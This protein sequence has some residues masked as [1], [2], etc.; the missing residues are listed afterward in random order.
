MLRKAVVWPPQVKEVVA[1]R[2]AAAEGN[3]NLNVSS[4]YLPQYQSVR[5][6]SKHE[7]HKHLTFSK[8]GKNFTRRPLIDQKLL[9][10]GAPVSATLDLGDMTKV[11]KFEFDVAA[12]NTRG[13]LRYQKAYAP[14]TNA[15]ETVLQLCESVFSK[16]SAKGEGYLMNAKITDSRLKYDLLSKLY[17]EFQHAVPNS[18]LH[19]METVGDVV[20]FYCTP[21]EIHT[22]YEELI[23]NKANLPPNLHV[24]KDPIRFQPGTDTDIFDGQTAFNKSSTIVTGLR[25]KKKFPGFQA[26]M[27]WP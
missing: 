17:N 10:Q 8:M 9:K 6:R 20:Q 13:F 1:S 25:A 4:V 26:K 19:M 14:P 21:I 22:P 12:L 15:K 27:T 18:M 16:E 7:T 5:A 23:R 24:Q 11:R 3:W 2:C